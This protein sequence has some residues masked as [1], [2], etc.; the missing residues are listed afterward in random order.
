VLIAAT[1]FIIPGCANQQAKNPS[2]E[3]SECIESIDQGKTDELS[4][5]IYY[6]SPTFLTPVPVSERDLIQSWYDY[7][8]VVSG[9]KLRKYIDL[10]DKL[11][12]SAFTPVS[13]KGTDGFAR[14]C[15]VFETKNNHK[16]F[17]VCM[18]NGKGGIFVNGIEVEADDVLYNVVIPFL[19]EDAAEKIKKCMGS[20][21]NQ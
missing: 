8:I 17:D 19:P 6:M 4:L 21:S 5:T 9:S 12:N 3:L 11:A 14:L 20:D 1:F 7:K 18:W 15:Y 2:A 13:E 16:I 10:I